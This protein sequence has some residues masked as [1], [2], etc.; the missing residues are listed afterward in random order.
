[1]FLD[2][3]R[4]PLRPSR[5]S[6]Q[7]RPVKERKRQKETNEIKQRRTYI[8]QD[9]QI[10]D[11]KTEWQGS[12]KRIKRLRKKINRKTEILFH[13]TLIVETNYIVNGD[14]KMNC[15]KYSHQL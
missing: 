13:E 5:T 9:D 12:K 1:M 7:Y 3:L 8:N 4:P 2:D 6:A 14:F 10:A 11:R 15:N